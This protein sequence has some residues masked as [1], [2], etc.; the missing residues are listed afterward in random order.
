[1]G[2]IGPRHRCRRGR[3]RP[4][5]RRR[6]DDVRLSS[7]ARTKRTA[8]I[9]RRS[10]RDTL[11]LSLDTLD[12]ALDEATR[13]AVEAELVAG[14]AHQVLAS[15][16]VTT[17][18]SGAF[19]FVDPDDPAAG[20]P[21][22]APLAEADDRGIVHAGAGRAVTATGSLPAAALDGWPEAGS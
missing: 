15:I 9:R 20:I 13:A 21:T 22:D 17:R 3:Q 10:G 1:V 7:A 19:V 2:W 8:A 4:S 14:P 12:L 6:G 5:P 18:S 11:D 16:A